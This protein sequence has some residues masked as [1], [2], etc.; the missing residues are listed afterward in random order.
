VRN[1]KRVWPTKDVKDENDRG[2]KMGGGRDGSQAAL[3]TGHLCDAC[4]ARVLTDHSAT[5]S[6][7]E[8]KK[9]KTGSGIYIK[10]RRKKSRGKKARTQQKGGW[11]PAQESPN[12]T[13]TRK[14]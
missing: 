10:K 11:D 7:P 9:E 3:K 5:S 12:D 14:S 13:I 1:I 8:K 4:P 6:K 2:A